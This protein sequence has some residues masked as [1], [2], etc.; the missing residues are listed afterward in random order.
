SLLEELESVYPDVFDRTRASRF[1]AATDFAI[2]SMLAH[3]YAVATRRGVEWPEV[4]GEYAYANTGHN[5]FRVKL[6]EMVRDRPT[7]LCLNAT[8]SDGVSLEKQVAP[9]QDFLR[10][11][12]PVPAMWERAESTDSE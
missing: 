8:L 6:A 9:L 5:S 10:R 11:R 3:Y 1:R 4:P 12:F 2:P 7:F